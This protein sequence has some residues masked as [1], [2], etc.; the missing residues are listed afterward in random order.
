MIERKTKLKEAKQETVLVVKLRRDGF[1]DQSGDG[2]W[3]F[4][5]GE[6]KRTIDLINVGHKR[7]KSWMTL[8]TNI[9]DLNNNIYVGS[10]LKMR[11]IIEESQHGMSV[12]A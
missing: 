9:Y 7:K 4:L 1:Q 12:N 6:A 3:T 2:F 11:N 10:F 5:E 8:N